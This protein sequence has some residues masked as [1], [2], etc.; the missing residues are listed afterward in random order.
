MKYPVRS[1]PELADPNNDGKGFTLVTVE[2][3]LLD[4]QLS[5]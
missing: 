1:Y 3:G 5:S 2:P 4:M